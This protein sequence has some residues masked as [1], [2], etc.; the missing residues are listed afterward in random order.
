VTVASREFHERLSHVTTIVLW[1]GTYSAD[2]RERLEV[3]ER[4]ERMFGYWNV[5]MEGQDGDWRVVAEAYVARDRPMGAPHPQV[6]TD[7]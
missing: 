6:T 5:R 2:G 1:A 4:Y 3:A 7:A